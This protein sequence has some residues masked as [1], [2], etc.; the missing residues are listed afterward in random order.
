MWKKH[1]SPSTGPASTVEKHDTSS[2]SEHG[3]LLG[4]PVVACDN[5]CSVSIVKEASGSAA[6]LGNSGQEIAFPMESEIKA[7]QLRK[8]GHEPTKRKKAVEA[9]YDDLGDDFSGLGGDLP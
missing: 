6:T 9:H 2:T 4:V 7:K 5:R 8:D 1:H 3:H